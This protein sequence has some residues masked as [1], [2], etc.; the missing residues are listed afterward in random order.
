MKKFKK[1]ILINFLIITT[2]ITYINN[3]LY[4]HELWLETDYNSKNNHINIMIGQNFNGT[5]F[6]FS[7]ADM[8]QLF[9][10]NKNNLQK[11][12]QRDGNFP[13]IQINIDTNKFNIINYETNYSFL[14]YDSFDDFE[15]FVKNQNSSYLIKNIDKTIIPKEN[16]KRFSK[17][18]I[19]NSNN[20]FIQKE[21]L[22]Y[23]IVAL[24][25]P[26]DPR[27]E[28]FEFRLLENNKPLKNFQVTIFSKEG[29]NFYKDYVKTNPNGEGKLRLFSNR[30]YLISAVL[31]KKASL[32]E[33]LKLKSDW[34]S[35]WASMTFY[36]NYNH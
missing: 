13:A 23:E 36:L 31:I 27:N 10:E 20:F 3:K 24:N 21:N 12:I 16:Y 8:K 19:S 26:F 9:L 25:S 35:Y 5:P 7:N 2:F 22:D 15:K 4:A 32:I 30:S 17:I 34:L 1:N 28:F 33:K 6:G 11:I 18:L 29:D 14:E